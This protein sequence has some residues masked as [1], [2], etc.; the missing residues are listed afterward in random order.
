[1]LKFPLASHILQRL[2]KKNKTHIIVQNICK[3]LSLPR[4]SKH[5]GGWDSVLYD[6]KEKLATCKN[7]K[8]ESYSTFAQAVQHKKAR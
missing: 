2:V 1:M 7:V 6:H 4:M 8:G 5:S 3:V